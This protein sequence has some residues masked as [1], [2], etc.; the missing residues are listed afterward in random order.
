MWIG[1][2]KPEISRFNFLVDLKAQSAA[3]VENGMALYVLDM[4]QMPM[5]SVINQNY[6]RVEG[7]NCGFKKNEICFSIL[8]VHH[9]FPRFSW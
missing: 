7:K 9:T 1:Q 8:P 5:K 2:G 4:K 3:Q 6:N